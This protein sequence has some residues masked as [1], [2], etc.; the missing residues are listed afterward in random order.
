VAFKQFDV[1]L[2]LDELG[3]HI[4]YDG[5]SL[6]H[7]GHFGYSHQHSLYGDGFSD[8]WNKPSR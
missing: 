4:G 3:Y 7:V 2:K 1:R 6:L 5:R 8:L